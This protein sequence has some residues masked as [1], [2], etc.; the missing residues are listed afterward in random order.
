[1]KSSILSAFGLLATLATSNPITKRTVPVHND[2]SCRSE[3]HPNPVVL[4]HGLGA[5]YYEDINLLELYLQQ[6]G[7]CTFSTTYGEYALFP[8]VGGLK[9]IKT[10]SDEIASFI[11][12]VQTKTGA[13]KVDLV[14]HSEG[15]FQVLYVTKFGKGIKE[16]VQ[17]VFAIAPPTHGTTFLSLYNVTDLSPELT[18]PLV[19][20]VLKTVGCSACADLLPQGDAVER[21]N[22]GPIAQEGISY[23]IL[24]STNDQLVVPTE[25]SFVR[26]EGVRNLYVQEFCPLDQVGHIGEA[27]DPNV[28]EL[29]RNALR[30]DLAGPEV[31]VLGFPGR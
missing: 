1:M 12:S 2:F 27:Y 4:L 23:T 11:K 26:E 24:T 7:Y 14:G 16:I 17:R 8:F 28:M 6:Q 13:A 31:C 10:S 20:Q 19:D 18:R 21:L 3:A 5:T 25:T 15:A 22:E 9:P 30:D 29:V